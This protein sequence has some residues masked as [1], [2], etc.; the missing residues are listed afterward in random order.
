VHQSEHGLSAVIQRSH[1]EPWSITGPSP[2]ADT[3]EPLP[4]YAGIHRAPTGWWGIVVHRPRGMHPQDAV[5]H[6]ER[7]PTPVAWLGSNATIGLYRLPTNELVVSARIPSGTVKAM[8]DVIA[9]ERG[10]EFAETRF[11]K[12]RIPAGLRYLPGQQMQLWFAL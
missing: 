6:F 8:Q 3:T 1:A 5:Q 9:A 10:Q 11:A 12:R 4:A 7:E 2:F